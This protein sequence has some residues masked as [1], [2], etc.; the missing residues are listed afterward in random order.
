MYAFGLYDSC[1]RALYSWV[2]KSDELICSL[3]ARV[4]KIACAKYLMKAYI[5][6]LNSNLA[7]QFSGIYI[8]IIS[9]IML[10]SILKTLIYEL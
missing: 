7:K 8:Y 9:I 3:H 4:A 6:K 10:V 2:I 1:S 5:L